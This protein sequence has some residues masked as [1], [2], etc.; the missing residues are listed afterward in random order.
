MT[1]NLAIALS[2]AL[3]QTPTLALVLT[4]P[5]NSEAARRPSA[6]GYGLFDLIEGVVVADEAAETGDAV[7]Q[8]TSG[9]VVFL[10]CPVEAHAAALACDRRD[11][12]DQFAAGAGAA[13]GRVDVQIL[14]IANFTRA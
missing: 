11:R 2:H 9:G 5:V 7:V 12:V 8:R 1:S 6:E 4:S 13:V 10:G 3:V 14:Q